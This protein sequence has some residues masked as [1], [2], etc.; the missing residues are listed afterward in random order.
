MTHQ[1][2][3]AHPDVLAQ[4]HKGS[5]EGALTAVRSLR[6]DF[7]ELQLAYREIFY[8]IRLLPVRSGRLDSLAGT[9]FS[10][11]LNVGSLELA[12]EALSLMSTSDLQAQLSIALQQQLAS[13]IVSQTCC[14]SEG[15]A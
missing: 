14:L 4:L 13:Q 11:L 8:A 10:H 5:I 7:S 2:T 1:H 3:K 15:F 9:A 6:L 12:G